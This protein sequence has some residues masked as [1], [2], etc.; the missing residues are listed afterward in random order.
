MKKN[1]MKWNEHVRQAAI[2]NRKEVEKAL[3]IK[4]QKPSDPF[5]QHANP[6]K[7]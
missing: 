2:R 3:G 6:T 1:L 7:K 4:H 5:I